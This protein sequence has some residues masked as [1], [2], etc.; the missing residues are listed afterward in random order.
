LHSN[1]KILGVTKNDGK[2][3]LKDYAIK[4]FG[5]DGEDEINRAVVLVFIIDFLFI[6]SVF[7]AMTWRIMHLVRFFIVT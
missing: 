2:L 1:T 6:L 3:P 5:N 4:L 7:V